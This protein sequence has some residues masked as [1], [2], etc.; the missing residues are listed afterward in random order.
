MRLILTHNLVF[1]RAL[2]FWSTMNIIIKILYSFFISILVYPW[3][4]N[5]KFLILRQKNERL[6]DNI[7]DQE[8]FIWQK[9]W[10]TSIHSF[11][12]R[13]NYYLVNNYPLMYRYRINKNVLQS[14]FSRAEFW[15]FR[16]KCQSLQ[17]YLMKKQMNW[18]Y[19]EY[20]VEMP[21]YFTDKN[22]FLYFKCR[23]NW[24]DAG[25]QI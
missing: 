18:S 10:Q 2:K 3:T 15:S 24:K 22:Y 1:T 14:T 19:M 5:F 13:W 8:D 20:Y 25:V 23:K 7:L 17:E 4:R 16:I 12:V 6:Y 9:I 21:Q 11:K